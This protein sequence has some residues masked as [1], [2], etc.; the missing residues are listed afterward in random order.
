MTNCIKLCNYL[1]LSKN[2]P[3]YSLIKQ[4]FS[5]LGQNKK[6]HIKS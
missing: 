2:K 4:I 3:D 5:K 6:N 1:Y